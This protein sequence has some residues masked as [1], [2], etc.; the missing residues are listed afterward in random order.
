MIEAL[1][2]ALALGGAVFVYRDRRPPE[3]HPLN[4]WRTIARGRY[5]R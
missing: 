1:A 3:S 4:N 5:D 2:L